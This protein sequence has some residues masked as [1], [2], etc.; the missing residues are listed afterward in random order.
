MPGCSLPAVAVLLIFANLS[1]GSVGGIAHW[2]CRPRVPDCCRRA[3]AATTNGTPLRS[4][5]VVVIT[6]LTAIALAA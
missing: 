6:L 4:V 2:C 5:L 3:S 1:G